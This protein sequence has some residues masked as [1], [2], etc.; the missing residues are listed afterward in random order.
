MRTRPNCRWKCWARNT[1]GRVARDCS[2]PPELSNRE[3][4]PVLRAAFLLC[5][6]G[7]CKLSQPSEDCC[8]GKARAGRDSVDREILE[9]GVTARC[10]ELQDFQHADHGDG[11]GSGQ[12]AMSRIGHPDKKTR[13]K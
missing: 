6:F 7:P 4:R 2:E 8:D 11:D 12:P 13:Q 3:C 10:P 5:R 9:P 1:N